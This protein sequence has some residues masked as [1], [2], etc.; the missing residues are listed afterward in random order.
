MIYETKCINP[1]SRSFIVNEDFIRP[2][3]F[4]RASSKNDRPLA[5]N[6]LPFEP[7]INNDNIFDVTFKPSKRA[8]LETGFW[9]IVVISMCVALISSNSINVC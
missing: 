8:C 7:P 4:L 6:E 2:S 9:G 3:P 5:S 1:R